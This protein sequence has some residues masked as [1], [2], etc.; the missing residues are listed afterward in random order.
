MQNSVHGS[1]ARD[2]WAESIKIHPTGGLEI[3]YRHSIDNY[4]YCAIDRRPSDQF[5][6]IPVRTGTR[7]PGDGNRNPRGA[8]LAKRIHDEISRWF[9]KLVKPSITIS[10]WR[11]VSNALPKT[12]RK[13]PQQLEL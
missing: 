1:S 10:R 12:F 13:K 3:A 5:H 8:K 11:M 6:V 4:L 7:N 9:L 2:S